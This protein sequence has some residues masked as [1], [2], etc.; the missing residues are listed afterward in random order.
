[1]IGAGG[2]AGPERRGQPAQA[3]ARA[4]RAA[5]DRGHHLVRVQEVLREGRGARRGAS[6]RSRSRSRRATHAIGMMRGVAAMLEKHHGVRI[7]DEAVVDAVRLSHRYIPARQ[8]PD[9]AVSVLDTA[10]ARVAIG[11]QA[12][13]AAIEDLRRRLDELRPRGGA[14][15]SARR[16]SA[17]TTTSGCRACAPDARRRRRELAALEARWE[18][19]KTLVARD[20]RA[21]REARGPGQ[22][23]AGAEPPPP[24]AD[25]ERETLRA[26]HERKRAEL[27][28]AAGRDAARP[29]PTSTRR[30]SPR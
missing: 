30:R 1:M 29:A 20:P 12:M 8:L 18:K 2:P 28:G 9:K 16:R 21:A 24:L 13:P 26:E 23:E 3:G 17:P 4:R 15:S 7:L 22:G 11:Q 5:H 10:C 27:D 6:R 19:E 14:C 25:A